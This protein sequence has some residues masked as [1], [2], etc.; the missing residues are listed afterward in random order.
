MDMVLLERT[1]DPTPPARQISSLIPSVLA[2]RAVREARNADGRAAL[3]CDKATKKMGV[4]RL[5]RP[6]PKF[7]GLGPVPQHKGLGGKEA[8]SRT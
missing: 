7:F 1:L 5:T 3:K 4:A 2:Q 8:W 6:T